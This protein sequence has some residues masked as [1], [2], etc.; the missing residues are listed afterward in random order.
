[1]PT[2]AE[3]AVQVGR[4]YREYANAT[5]YPP[6]FGRA[7][8]KTLLKLIHLHGAYARPG[9]ISRP[10]TPQK[11]VLHGNAYDEYKSRMQRFYI[12]MKAG[13]SVHEW[14]ISYPFTSPIKAFAIRFLRA[15]ITGKRT[16]SPRCSILHPS[17]L[18]NDGSLHLRPIKLKP[19]AKGSLVLC[20]ED[21]E[22]TFR[23]IFCLDGQV[24]VVLLAELM[25]AN[26]GIGYAVGT[27]R[28]NLDTP[29]LF[30]WILVSLGMVSALE[31]CLLRPLENHF[32]KWQS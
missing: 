27:T 15:S 17:T 4:L 14:I 26:D 5:Y 19:A 25:G 1:M 13:V 24:R 6:R 30:A 8:N 20:C 7:K 22:R 2:R 23:L 11:Q 29:R 3:L 21:S 16:R 18:S 10:P 32:R 12:D 28:T 9:F 31:F